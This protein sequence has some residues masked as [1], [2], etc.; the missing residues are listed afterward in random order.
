MVFSVGV[1]RGE[2]KVLT[3]PALVERTKNSLVE[4]RLAWEYDVESQGRISPGRPREVVTHGVLYSREGLVLVPLGA[5]EPQIASR[6]DAAISVLNLRY[7]QFLVKLSDGTE[8]NGKVVKRFP[9]S[10]TAL[11]HVEGIAGV[12][13]VERVLPGIASS[14]SIGQAY[15]QLLSIDYGDGKTTLCIPTSCVG[16]VPVPD[17]R[18][19]FFIFNAALPGAAIVDQHANLVGVVAKAAYN[20]KFPLLGCVPINSIVSEK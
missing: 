19:D 8:R 17:T 14:V 16:S 6:G 5:I 4:I 15:F 1:I 7:S 12:D 13:G 20:T 11:V 9:S 18:G 10:D 3:A 2:D